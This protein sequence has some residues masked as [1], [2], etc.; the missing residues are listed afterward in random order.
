MGGDGRLTRPRDRRDYNGDLPRRADRTAPVRHATHRAVEATESVIGVSCRAKHLPRPDCNVFVEAG[1]ESQLDG[2]A[3]SGN[4]SW[5]VKAV[6]ECEHLNFGEDFVVTGRRVSGE[7]ACVQ[8]ARARPRRFSCHATLTSCPPAAATLKSPS[9]L[10]S[11]P[12][13]A[14]VQTW[15]KTHLSAANPHLSI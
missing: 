1:L 10:S 3:W 2:D 4:G 13:V 9:G 11:A 14:N 6:W 7:A 5:N 15:Y 12:P 8:W